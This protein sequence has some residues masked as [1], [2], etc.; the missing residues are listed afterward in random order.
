MPGLKSPDGDGRSSF[1]PLAV[2]WHVRFI[3]FLLVPPEGAFHPIESA[4]EGANLDRRAIH[5]FRLLDDGSVVTLYELRGNRET[6]DEVLEGH[7][8]VESVTTTALG[9]RVFAHVQFVPNDLTER[10]YAIPQNHDIVLDMPMEYADRGA[11]RVTAIGTLETFRE[12]MAEMTEEV[13]LRLLGTGDY[14]PTDDGLYA[15]LTERQREILAA[16]VEVGYYEEPRQAN[17]QDIADELGI[18]TGTVGEHLRKIEST[19]LKGVL[20]QK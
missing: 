9:E 3:T 1:P 11:L 16:A 15:Q 10:I 17:Y 7:G 6:V 20:P 14:V 18:S 8:S 4:L 2:D 5:R 19:V 12:A 13:G